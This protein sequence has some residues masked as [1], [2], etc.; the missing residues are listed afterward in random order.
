MT[1]ADLFLVLALGIFILAWWVRMLPARQ[2][3]LVASALTAIAAAGWGLLDD[4]W[5]ALHGLYAAGLFLAVA[6]GVLVRGRPAMAGVPFVSGTVLAACAA[7]GLFQIYLFPVN[8]LPQPAGPYP[9]GV[10]TFELQDASRTGVLAAA[11]DEPRRLLVR[12]WYPAARTDGLRRMPYFSEQEADTTAR[13]LGTLFG[14]PD[15]LS[16]LKHV[17]THSYEN[18]PLASAGGELP[19][20]FYSHGYV[21]YAGQHWAMMEDLASHGYVVFSVQ[22]PFDASPTVFPNGDVLPMDPAIFEDEEA[23]QT[24][25]EA[26]AAMSGETFDERLEGMIA[27]GRQNLESAGRILA[28]RDVWVEDRLFVHDRLAAGDVPDS[29]A[30]IVAAS[31]L[32]RTGQMGMS[33]GGST[34]GVICLIDPRCAAA[35]NLDGLDMH[36]LPFNAEMP[37]PFM[38]LN[39]D[40]AKL[41]PSEGL[42]QPGAGRTPND[43]SYE[44]LGREGL[45][46]D[47]HRYEIAGAFHLG[48]ADFPLFLRRPL[49]D[50]FVGTTPPEHLVGGQIDLVR[51]FFD[52]YLRG[53]ENGFPQ[54]QLDRHGDWIHPVDLTSLRAWWLA[55]PAEERARLEARIEAVRALSVHYPGDAAPE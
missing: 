4:R 35:V 5:Q 48:I 26:V 6:I 53:E 27:A 15:L 19:T 54:A 51:G 29:V 34:T 2:T 39:S 20:I 10:R 12:V 42:E 11:A 1:A 32:E 31:D 46:E 21:L 13:G 43:F 14:Q 33:F 8:A 41:Y 17:R 23:Q 55:K 9:V 30:D 47:I 45:R 36:I 3:V 37:V 49:R 44:S 18:A 25:P 52:R 50:D 16:H 40:M 28:S 38:D 7:A 24:T 22:H